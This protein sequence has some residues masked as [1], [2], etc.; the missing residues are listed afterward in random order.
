MVLAPLYGI[1]PL[2]QPRAAFLKVPRQIQALR[3]MQKER[4]PRLEFS[5]IY[6]I[7]AIG[8][9]VVASIWPD[10]LRG[11]TRVWPRVTC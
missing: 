8:P 4:D 10:L 1:L 11:A 5:D 3:A 9:L 7:E 2:R 6:E